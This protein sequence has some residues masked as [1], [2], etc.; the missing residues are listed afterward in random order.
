MWKA[1]LMS[2]VRIM[3]LITNKKSRH[4]AGLKKIHELFFHQA[5]VENP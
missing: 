5:K 1:V 4:N 3:Q 2:E